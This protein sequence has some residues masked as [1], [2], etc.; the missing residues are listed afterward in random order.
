MGRNLCFHLKAEGEILSTSE[1]VLLY[2]QGSTRILSGMYSSTSEEVLR[3]NNR[4]IMSGLEFQVTVL[5]PD[6]FLGN[7]V[8]YHF[9]QVIFRHL[10]FV[11]YLLQRKR[12]FFQ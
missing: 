1:G 10:H 4:F 6:D 12:I 7:Q 11:L 2:F 8:G 9:H 5:L 3:S